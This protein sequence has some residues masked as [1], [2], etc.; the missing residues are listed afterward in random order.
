MDSREEEEEGF[1]S[2][3]TL[4]GGL[5]I[6]QCAGDMLMS[7]RRVRTE[8]LVWQLPALPGLMFTV[9]MRNKLTCLLL[10]FSLNLSGFRGT[11]IE[12]CCCHSSFEAEK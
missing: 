10:R 7:W 5:M 8:L 9:C 12:L 2:R 6:G 4:A 1:V 11:A 3:V